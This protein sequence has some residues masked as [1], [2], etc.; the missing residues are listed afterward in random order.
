MDVLLIGDGARPRARCSV[1]LRIGVEAKGLT[2]ARV[3]G[4]L[5]VV[6]VCVL[7]WTHGIVEA[8]LRSGH[9]VFQSIVF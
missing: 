3:D 5:G 2:L 6:K 8:V 7:R 9:R 1:G 4:W